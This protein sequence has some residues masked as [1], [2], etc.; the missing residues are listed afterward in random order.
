MSIF[1]FF[2]GYW[3]RAQLLTVHG[4][5]AVVSFVEYGD[6][7]IVSFSDIRKLSRILQ[8]IPFMAIQCRLAAVHLD[9]WPQKS[10]DVM[11]NICRPEML[12]SATCRPRI[13]DEVMEI[14][15]LFV[16]DVDVVEAVLASLKEEPIPPTISPPISP[17]QSGSVYPTTSVPQLEAEFLFTLV[18]TETDSLETVPEFASDSSALP[19]D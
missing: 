18:K 1:T 15:S 11:K 10:I 17:S 6:R 5:D 4:E 2:Q 14:E 19:V 16:G 9:H 8:N 12:S 3:Y 13:N 7:Q